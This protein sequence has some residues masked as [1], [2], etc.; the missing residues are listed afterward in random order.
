MLQSVSQIKINKARWLF[1]CQF[2]P[3]LNQQYFWRQPGSIENWLEP[4]TEPTWWNFFSHIRET[5]CRN[6]RL[7]LILIYDRYTCLPKI[8]SLIV[9]DHYNAIALLSN[10]WRTGKSDGDRTLDTFMYILCTST[11]CNGEILTFIHL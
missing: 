8:H 2:W 11:N 5:L 10:S 1:L 6:V 4:K 7:E 9:F 3:L